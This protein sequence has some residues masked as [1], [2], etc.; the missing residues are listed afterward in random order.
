MGFYL[1]SEEDRKYLVESARGHEGIFL[2]EREFS[3]EDGDKGKAAITLMLRPN[4]TFYY[5]CIVDEIS[6]CDIE[7][8]NAGGMIVWSDLEMGP[9]NYSLALGKLI[10][11]NRKDAQ[12]G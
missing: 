5:R 1:T 8:V 6:V 3:F 2:Y 9:N 10:E 7:E 4:G 12:R 11:A